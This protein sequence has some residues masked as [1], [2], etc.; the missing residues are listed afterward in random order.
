VRRRSEE[1]EDKKI[2]LRFIYIKIFSFFLSSCCSQTNN[3]E[4]E[5][6]AAAVAAAT[7]PSSAL[8]SSLSRNCILNLSHLAA[9]RCKQQQ[10]KRKTRIIV[11]MLMFATF[12][13]ISSP[14]RTR[15][16]FVSLM[17]SPSFIA[18]QTSL[19]HSL[20]T[21]THTLW[22]NFKFFLLRKSIKIQF[23]CVL[24]AAAARE[25]TH[26]REFMYVYNCFLKNG[27][28]GKHEKKLSR[29]Y[30]KDVCLLQTLACSSRNL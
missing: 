16:T 28:G 5:K 23:M 15:L 9:E 18:M 30:N 6:A 14:P 19:S 10:Q 22:K 13:A 24:A 4:G 7:T 3:S 8:H 29:S 21:H 25:Y 20:C 26:E 17:S 11:M 12:Y 27:S 2:S 1:E